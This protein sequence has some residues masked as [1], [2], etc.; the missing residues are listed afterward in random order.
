MAPLGPA[1]IQA[2]AA[3]PVAWALD[4]R[5]R[6]RHGPRRSVHAVTR[7]VPGV[8]TQGLN[9]TVESNLYPSYPQGARDARLIIEQERNPEAETAQRP[10]PGR[11]GHPSGDGRAGH[12]AARSATSP[13]APALGSR[14]PRARVRLCVYVRPSAGSRQ[15]KGAERRTTAP[16]A[17]PDCKPAAE[18]P[19]RGRLPR[20]PSRGLWEGSGKSDYVI[21]RTTVQIR[22]S[23]VEARHRFSAPTLTRGRD[24]R[25][26]RQQSRDKKHRAILGRQRPSSAS[27]APRP[28]PRGGGRAEEVRR[29]A[30]ARKAA[31]AGRELQGQVS[32]KHV[33][34]RGAS[35]FRRARKEGGEQVLARAGSAAGSRGRGWEQTDRA[36]TP[37]AGAGPRHGSLASQSLCV[38]SKRDGKIHRWA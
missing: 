33:S 4:H 16:R 13:Q 28:A 30:R 1:S 27:H 20:T 25:M 15:L 32:S 23:N 11:R 31:G 36:P 22:F 9:Y 21:S 7:Q 17:A 26:L 5:C 12:S 35:R 18:V 6:P 3:A 2:A 10:R 14:V 29:N 37:G 8:T 34:R 24:G 38:S 19:V